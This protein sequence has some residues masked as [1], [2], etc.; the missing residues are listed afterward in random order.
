MAEIGIACSRP[1]FRA[2]KRITPEVESTWSRRSA[3][4]S[5]G[6]IPVAASSSAK[7]RSTLPS[8]IAASQRARSA[9]GTMRLPCPCRFRR[10]GACQ[11]TVS[12][13]WA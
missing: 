13:A 11:R 9:A 8:G 4:A 3:A 6:R 5:L 10:R 7:V 12:A 1:V 2:V